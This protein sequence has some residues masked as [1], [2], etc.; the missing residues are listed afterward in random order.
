MKKYITLLSMLTFVS[1]AATEISFSKTFEA[2]IKPDTLVS[3]LTFTSSKLS[4]ELT[5]QKLTAISDYMSSIKNIKI[6]GGSY[7]INPHM[8]YENQKS[9]QDGY[10]GYVTHN[11]SSKNSKELNKF[12]RDAQRAGEKE[13]LSVSVSNVAWNVSPE[14]N[15]DAFSDSLR[16]ES[17]LWARNYANKLSSK[18]SLSCSV[19]KIDFVSSG[20]AYPVAMKA[21]VGENSDRAPT[22]MQDDKKIQLNA[23]VTVVCK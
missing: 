12:I 2:S 3:S 13:K 5:T 6:E 17:I 9:Y 19:S 11:A 8:V 16:V 7:S 23:N 20:Y 18:L 22:P 4:Q 21:M 10:D 1:N 14:Q 15:I